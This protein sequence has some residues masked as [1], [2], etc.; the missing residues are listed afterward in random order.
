VGI[1]IAKL[2]REEEKWRYCCLHCSER[3]KIEGTDGFTD[4]TGEGMALL[5]AVLLRKKRDGGIDGCDAQRAGEIKE[6]MAAVLIEWEAW[7]HRWLRK[8]GKMI[9]NKWLQCPEWRDCLSDGYGA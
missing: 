9:V 7:P 1:L 4:Q 2:L 5:M 3:R 8:G 6:E